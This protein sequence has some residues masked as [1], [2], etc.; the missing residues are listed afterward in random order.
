[1]DDVERN[2]VKLFQSRCRVGSARAM[3][4]IGLAASGG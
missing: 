2:D 4:L 1:M 3:A